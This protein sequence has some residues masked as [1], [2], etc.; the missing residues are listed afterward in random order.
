ME[1][2][3]DGIVMYDCL[4]VEGGACLKTQRLKVSRG[5]NKVMCHADWHRGSIQGF[6]DKAR[7][8]SDVRN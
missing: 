3:L 8:K 1:L 2:V 7:N 4:V 5:W 6:Q